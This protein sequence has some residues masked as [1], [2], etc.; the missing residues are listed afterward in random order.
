MIPWGKIV[1]VEKISEE[2]RDVGIT[3]KLDDTGF[4]RHPRSESDDQHGLTS[5]EQQDLAQVVLAHDPTPKPTKSQLF[6]IEWQQ[7]A[8]TALRR[9]E[10]IEEVLK[11]FV[12]AGL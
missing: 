4:I 7:P 8:T 5:V 10:I 2:L 1:N 9:N 12:E 6:L 3:G 11:H